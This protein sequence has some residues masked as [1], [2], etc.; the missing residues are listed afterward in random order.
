[1]AS[2]LVPAEEAEIV[3]DDAS[4]G[5]RDQRVSDE[6]AADLRRATAANTDR[7]YARWWRM[8]LDW[9]ER[10][11][12]TP[13]PMTAQT[14]AEFIGHL[15]R[16]TSPTT[17]KPY[18]PA[19]LDQALSAIRTAH[20]RAGFEGQ[21]NSRAARD[22]IK[23]HRQDRAR[24]GWRPRRAKAVTLDVLR[25][26]LAQCDTD[27]LSGRRDATILI[28]GYGLM[29]R[30]SEIAACT[31]DQV[32]VTDDW[33][34][35]FIP[36][37]KTDT[38][39]QGEDV[40]IPRAIAPDI[41]AGAV[42]SSYLVGLA[43]HGI[44]DGHLIR[45]IDVWGNVGNSMSGEAVNEIVKKLAKA[46]N[47]TDAER[48]TAHGLRAGG[49]TDAAERGVPVPFIAEHGRWSKNST[50]VLTYVRPAERRKNNPFLP[51]DPRG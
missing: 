16:S 29:G 26:L 22:I 36:M 46:A 13:L 41:D 25:L 40:D 7:A 44:T 38:N 8:A 18:S 5:E 9:C 45:R 30:R 50:Q 39:A 19:S 17:G 23:V 12:R 37:S 43:E 15:K 6:T 10:E 48:T 42:V 35:V 1:M 3:T 2:E 47:L 49:P 11:G 24:D 21:P 51:R 28:L 20:F 33:V 4:Q 34:T 32:T 14:V 27:S 31:I